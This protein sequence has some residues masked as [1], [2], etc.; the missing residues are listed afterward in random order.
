MKYNQDNALTK[1]PPLFKY[2]CLENE[3]EKQLPPSKDLNNVS[4]ILAIA[5][6]IG[7]RGYTSIE[8]RS[9]SG[10]I[11]NN[12]LCIIADKLIEPNTTYEMNR[13][14][15]GGSYNND[16]SSMQHVV[17]DKV[18]CYIDLVGNKVMNSVI[19]PALKDH[20]LKPLCTQND[21][22]TLVSGGSL[23]ILS[24]M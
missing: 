5:K 11:D 14:E 10:L 4:R 20:P 13:K 9:I 15:C 22:N 16:G 7:V 6:V 3:I 21:G 23:L 8:S 24:Y 18:E 2:S 1:G 19:I 17:I 12:C